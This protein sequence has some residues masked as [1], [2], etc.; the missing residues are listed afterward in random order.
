MPQLAQL[1]PDVE[2]LLAIEP[3][4]LGGCLLQ[5]M[6]G[7]PGRKRMLTVGS[8]LYELFEGSNPPYASQH[9]EAVFRELAETWNWLETQGLIVWPD[10]ANGRSGF[11]VPSRRG[12]KLATEEAFP[13]FL[14]GTALPR[15]FLHPRIAEKV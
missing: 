8:W 15:E 3:E 13:Q 5:I 11:R 6:N 2:V 10:E 1:I 14:R 4:Q 7:R 9:R 12:E